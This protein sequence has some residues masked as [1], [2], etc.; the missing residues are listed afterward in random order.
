MQDI[1]TFVY[2]D[3][4]ATGL[5][6]L[7]RPRVCEISLIA[8]DTSDVLDMH[9]PLL[10]SISGRTNEVETCSPRIVNKLTLCV[11][12]MATIAP[13]VSS[14]TGLDNY[15]LTGQSKFDKNIGNLLNTFLS[16]L[17]SPVC[18]VAHNGSQYD[19]PLLKAELE[20]A[21]TKLGSEILCV[22]SYLGI[23]SILKNS[24]QI[25]SE[26]KAVAEIANAG[27]FDTVM[28]EDTCAQIKT[29]IASD[30]VKYLPCSSKTLQ[31]NLI[32]Q[33][34]DHSM[35][36]LSVSTVSQQKNEST[37]TRSISLL[38]PKHRPKKLK[39]IKHADISKC[40]KKL[41]FSDCNMPTS[42]S[43]INLHKHFFGCPPNSS[44]G[45]EVDCLALMRITAVLGNDWLEWAQG[46]CTQFVKYEA[47]WSMP[48][49][50]NI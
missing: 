48:R 42:F 7:G 50:T 13:L 22:D 46:N 11:Y 47:M 15:N 6:S 26:L 41:N 45:A 33:E 5:K 32:H 16:C 4:E 12:P 27:E 9:E 8:V 23:R 18:L 43:L 28:M 21:G 14:M 24:Q 38:Y 44:H 20:K 1:Q 36:A 39:E 40:R 2:F 49:E 17:P 25:E 30:R 10:N 34:A 31:G 35:S 19:F 37:P 29:K 3:L